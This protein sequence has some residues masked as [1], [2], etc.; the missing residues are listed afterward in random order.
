M[1]EKKEYLYKRRGRLR[2]IRYTKGKITDGKAVYDHGYAQHSAKAKPKLFPSQA[3]LQRTSPQI[4][5]FSSAAAEWYEGIMPQI[6]ESKT[7]NTS[8]T[9]IWAADV[10]FRSAF[11]SAPSI[12]HRTRYVE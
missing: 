11:G 5:L 6:K 9:L 7:K 4:T 10:F 2:E 3:P 1:P 8:V 12:I